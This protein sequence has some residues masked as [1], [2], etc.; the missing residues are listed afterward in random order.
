ML[1]LTFRFVLDLLGGVCLDK[2]FYIGV[3]VLQAVECHLHCLISPLTVVD[4]HLGS[5]KSLV[6]GLVCQCLGASVVAA[7]LVHFLARPVGGALFI[8]VSHIYK[9]NVN[10]TPQSYPVLS[11]CNATWC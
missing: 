7:Y 6:T 8:I 9:N 2:G 11:D 3:V 5:T 4:S 10:R 1:L